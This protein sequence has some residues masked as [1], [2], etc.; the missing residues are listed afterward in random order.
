VNETSTAGAGLRQ[1]AATQT[2]GAPAWPLWAFIVGAV[3]IPS[4]YLH[5]LSTPFDFSDLN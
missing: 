4:L 2:G 3:L 1:S 5:N